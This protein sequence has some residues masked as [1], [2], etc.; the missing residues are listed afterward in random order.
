MD[1]MDELIEERLAGLVISD[2]VRQKLDKMVERGR[3]KLVSANDPQAEKDA[4]A[5]LNELTRSIQASAVAVETEPPADEGYER[6]L[7][8]DDALALSFRN[9]CPKWPWC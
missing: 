1:W 8:T 5:S 7:V 3:S 4:R 6:K 2:S 9:F